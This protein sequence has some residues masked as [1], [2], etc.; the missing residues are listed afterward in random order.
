MR[1]IRPRDERGFTLIELLVV[2]VILGIIAAVVVFSVGGVADKGKRSACQYDVKT[3]E[4]AEESYFSQYGVYADYPT[5]V[6][7][8]LLREAPNSSA[9]TVTVNTST[10]EVTAAPDCSAL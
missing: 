10:G 4:T 2:I 9:Y 8:K 1:H 7:E 6:A 3:I 5:L